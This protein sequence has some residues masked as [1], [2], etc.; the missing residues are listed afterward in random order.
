MD[1]KIIKSEKCLC[2]CCMEIHEVKTVLIR[3]RITFKQRKVDYDA[4]YQY[5]DNSDE[6]YM[7][8]QQIQENEKRLFEENDSKIKRTNRSYTISLRQ[9]IWH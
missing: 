4:L 2:V 5:C 3:E 9:R 8:E 1:M 7:N 6:L